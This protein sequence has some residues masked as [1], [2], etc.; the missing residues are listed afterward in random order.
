MRCGL[1]VVH[2][3]ALW[4]GERERCGVLRWGIMRPLWGVNCF[5]RTGERKETLRV[6]V[7]VYCIL[8]AYEG[9]MYLAL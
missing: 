7:L 4:L 9:E 2:V 6:M 3:R 1:V 8:D 5:E